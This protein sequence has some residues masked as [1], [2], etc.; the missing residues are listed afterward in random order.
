M[1][2]IGLHHFS[3]LT[4]VERDFTRFENVTGDWTAIK[5]DR[6]LVHLTDHQKFL[7]FLI[8]NG[9]ELL[10]IEETSPMMINQMV[11]LLRDP[12]SFI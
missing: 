9:E 4:K 2:E 6:Y 3:D 7:Y 1:L 5:E 11:E 8:C 10:E 12:I